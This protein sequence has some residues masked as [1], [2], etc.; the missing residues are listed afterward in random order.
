[1]STFPIV[2]SGS[3]TVVTS[4]NPVTLTPQ[5]QQANRVDV[6]ANYGNTGTIY[7]GGALVNKSTPT[8]IGLKPGDVYS[9]E[10]MSDLLTIWIDATVSG[11]SVTFNWW[12]GEIN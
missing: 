9:I 2:N 3:R 1:M 10:K 5:S 12:I 4:G 7:L 6:Q 11:D 8:G